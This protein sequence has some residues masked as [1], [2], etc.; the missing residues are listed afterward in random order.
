MPEKQKAGKKRA[1]AAKKVDELSCESEDLRLQAQIRERLYRKVDD[2]GR[3]EF[4]SEQSRAL[5]IFFDLV[6]EYESQRDFHAVCVMIPKVLFGVDAGLYLYNEESDLTCAYSTLSDARNVCVVKGLQP[7]E[8]VCVGNRFCCPIRGNKR[9]IDQLPFVPED[10]VIGYIELVSH[11][12]TFS[13]HDLLFWEKYANRIGFQQHLRMIHGV[14]RDHLK[15]IR[16]LVKDIGHNVIVPNMY[17]KLYFN[18]LKR[19]LD[20]FGALLN[21]DGEASAQKLTRLHGRLEEQFIEISRHYEQTSLY[22]ETLL[23]QSHF[24]KGRYV[25]ERRPCHLPDV[26][27]EPQLKQHSGRFRDNDI[28]I[29]EGVRSAKEESVTVSV[30]IG[31]MAQVYSNLFTNAAKYTGE[32]KNGEKRVTVG[33]TDERGYFDDGRDAVRFTVAST[34]SPIG[35][36]D[37]AHLF[38]PGYRGVNTNTQDGSGHGLFFVQQIV[39][40]HGGVVE[41]RRRLGMNE[42]HII[43]PLTDADPDGG[44]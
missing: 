31:L 6:Q 5:N 43:L 13:E 7:I 33:W 32:D 1:S 37:I 29:E 27:I 22:L 42:F 24:E 15:F 4:P 10:D 34:G 9:F 2:Y 16:N 41:Y 23:R 11:T 28:R 17:F 8:P 36:R 20:E 25:L 14:N 3:Y 18:R 26:I 40:L 12:G 38:E 30:D 19:Q 21:E 44:S 35:R 39:D